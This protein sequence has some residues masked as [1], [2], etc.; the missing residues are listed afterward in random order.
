MHYENQANIVFYI[1]AGVASL[2]LLMGLIGMIHIWRLGKAP[3]LN[4]NIKISKWI[5]SI[6]KSSI[7]ETQILEYGVLAWLAHIMIFWGFMSL[8]LLTSFHFVLNWFTPTSSSFF[9][10]FKA[11]NGDLFLA[12]WG[13]FWGLIMLAGVLIAL[14]RRYILKP[15]IISTISSDSIA[16]WFLFVLTIS[17]FLCEAVRLAAHPGAHDAAYSFAVNWLVPFLK[18]FN[19]TE[20]SLT[21]L[22]WVHAILSFLFIAYIP[23]SKFRHIFSSPLDFSFV[24][25]GERYSKESWLKRQ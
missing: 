15:E 6:L 7:L 17:G 13:D 1:L 12:L 20:T 19:L 22:F 14:F 11:G 23:F 16:I 5:G 3:T 10:Y 8:L 4:K 25:A 18:D 9:Y 24:T 2:I 21:Y